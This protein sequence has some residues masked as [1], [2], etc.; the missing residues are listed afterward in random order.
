MN[1]TGKLLLIPVFLLLLWFFVFAGRHRFIDGDEGFYLLAARLV[2]QHKTPYLDFLYTQAPLLPYVYGIWL[3]L[4]G[5][6]WIAA[7]GLSALLTA[8]IGL[9]VYMHVSRQTRKWGA[10][11]AAVVL[12]ASSTYVFAWFPIVKTFSL[13]LLFLFFTYI[14]VAGLPSA[15]SRWLLA[16]AGLS[17]GLAVDTRSY[18]VGLLPVFLWWI[19]RHSDTR[20]RIAE[21]LWFMAGFVVGIAPSLY[22]FALSPDIYLF[23]NLGYHAL[24]SGAGLLGY[25]RWKIHIVRVVL[26]GRDENGLQ[27]AVL[28]AVSFLAIVALWRQR[29]ASFLLAFLIAF[30]L[31]VISILPTPPLIQYFCVCMPFLIVAAVCSV[32][33][34]LN[35]LRNQGAKRLMAVASFVLLAGFVVS[36]APSFRRYLVTGDR[37]IGIKNTDDASNW[38][39]DRVTEVSKAI[40]HLATPHEE[41][42]SFWPGYIFASKADP[43][44]GFEN[45]FGWMITGKLTDT[46]REKYHILSQSDV[47]AE[48][49]AHSPRIVVVGNQE[50]FDGAPRMS[51]CAKILRSN[52]YTAISAVGDTS[53]FVY[54]GGWPTK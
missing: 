37:V 42:G 46:Q 12:F 39:L 52:N 21:L 33:E 11:L 43:Y 4:A 15:S 44:P 51:A 8:L 17:F 49:A 32:S 47:E 2:L 40:D 23:N 24:R 35:S 13:A 25:W 36:A 18:L 31:G 54:Q 7:R 5:F 50:F 53:I 22:L 10:G 16:L 19:F 3:K 45:D 14:V 41:I 26:T 30:F 9:L 20:S 29:G 48:F 38:T 6:S 28:S 34:F 1:R 27:L